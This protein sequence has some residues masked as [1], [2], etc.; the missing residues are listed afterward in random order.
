MSDN[1]PTK[2]SKHKGIPVTDVESAQKALLGVMQNSKEQSE[3]TEEEMTTQDEV[4]EQ[5]ND[6]A[7]SVQTETDDKLISSADVENIV[8]E[9][10]TEEVEKPET[11]TIKVDGKNVEVTLDEL[12]AGY[13]RQADY[14]HKTR[15]LSEQ[16]K[17]A[18][19][20][21]AATRQ[22]RDRY[23]SQLEK[24]DDVVGSELKTLEKTDWE[25]LRVE[26]PTDYLLKKGRLDDLEKQQKLVVDEKNKIEEAKKIEFQKKWQET[27]SEN[28]KII[29]DKIP[30]YFHADEGTKI[31]NSIRK[32]AM[33]QGLTEQEIDSM[34]DARAVKIL[35]DAMLYDQLQKTQIS[36]KKSK[37]VPKV[38]KPG[39]STTK[40]DI[41]T[42]KVKRQK[43][44]LRR[45]GK[46]DD[47]ASL[48]KSIL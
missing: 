3:S 4:V 25:R 7:E 6:V 20:E 40:S 19:E 38:T 35:Y 11:Y 47:A 43:S 41:D 26:N 29:S 46:V 32:Y 8:D 12:R 13:S 10:P 22:E 37:V 39:T 14:T 2:E 28:K 15:V 31:Q 1:I 9:Q 16:R 18:D 33:D 48:I 23:I 17:Q 34:V 30:N 5:A 21:L 36:K 45:S 24:L 44:R 27:L 42:E